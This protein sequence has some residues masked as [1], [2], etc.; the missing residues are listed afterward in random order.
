MKEKCLALFKNHGNCI[1]VGQRSGKEI[2][3]KGED[4]MQILE[5][6]NWDG[7][8]HDTYFNYI[9]ETAKYHML[10]PSAYEKTMKI[11]LLFV[12]RA[13]FTTKNHTVI[14]INPIILAIMFLFFTVIIVLTVPNDTSSVS[15]L[16][17]FAKLDKF[18]FK[19]E[20]KKENGNKSIILEGGKKE[21]L[22]I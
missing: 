21:C 14:S 6:L 12:F 19:F 18:Y 8:I 20:C 7:L 4:P 10:K 15:I 1:L 11:L 3:Y 17:K 13:S 2:I 16:R 9:Q 22:T 5:D